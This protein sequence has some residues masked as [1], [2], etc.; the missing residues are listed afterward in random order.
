VAAKLTEGAL[1]P[2]GGSA[3]LFI[4]SLVAWA[5]FRDVRLALMAP[6]GLSAEGP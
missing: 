5:V 2:C 1:G 4:G 3:P 6:G